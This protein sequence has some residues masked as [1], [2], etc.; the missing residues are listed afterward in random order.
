MAEVIAKDIVED[1]L[2]LLLPQFRRS[3]RLRG[4]VKSV[5]VN[6]QEVDDVALQIRDNT[7][8][9]TAVGAQLDVLGKL[10]GLL[11]GGLSDEEYRQQL[12]V[13]ISINRAT[14]SPES[15][16]NMLRLVTGSNLVTITESYP[17]A[18]IVT[19][20]EGSERINQNLL[21]KLS[22]AGVRMTL[23]GTVTPVIWTPSNINPETN[24]PYPS[25]AAVLP[26]VADLD[27]TNMSMANVTGS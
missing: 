20:P 11:R 12:L 4:L 25:A 9:L 13:E 8:I 17:A 2:S 15:I 26:N 22:P 6:L 24:T 23:L 7:G 14:G 5:L 19:A 18:I 27:T 3:N 10:I 16:L 1:G 21:D